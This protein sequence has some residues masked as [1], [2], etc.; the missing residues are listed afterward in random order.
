[1]AEKIGVWTLAVFL[2]KLPESA[3]NDLILTG[4][5]SATVWSQRDVRSFEKKEDKQ[6]YS[7][8]I[9]VQNLAVFLSNW[10]KQRKMTQ[11]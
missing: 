10:R 1:M 6:A 7:M 5:I 2:Y 8:K 11:L 3:E 4:P 9:G